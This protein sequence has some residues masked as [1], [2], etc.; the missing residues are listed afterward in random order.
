MQQVKLKVVALKLCA[1]SVYLLFLS[2]QLILRYT[3]DPT[4]NNYPGVAFNY[5]PKTNIRLID[6][7]LN[8]RPAIRKLKLTKRFVHEEHLLI[9][10]F[11]N[12][13]SNNFIIKANRGFASLPRLCNLVVSIAYLR[14]PPQPITLVC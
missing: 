1:V 13:F 6:K 14:G 2:V 5:G 11:T 12:E 10:S 9:Y 4:Y 7:P 8:N 3:S